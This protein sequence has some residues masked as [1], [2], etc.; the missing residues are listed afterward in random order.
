M[1]VEKIYIRKGNLFAHPGGL[2]PVN[3]SSYEPILPATK[4]A[5][6]AAVLGQLHTGSG[7]ILQ[8]I[9]L[10][11]TEYTPLHE[12]SQTG[13][14]W[15]NYTGNLFPATMDYAPRDISALN[16]TSEDFVTSYHSP[17]Y[18][19]Q[20]FEATGDLNYT[21]RIYGCGRFTFAVRAHEVN[22]SDYLFV[23]TVPLYRAA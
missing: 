16:A 4:Q 10:Q 5:T 14:V 20:A 22:D 1:D 8:M 6:A 21:A 9:S 2:I 15:S 11:Q 12:D 17:Y 7:S 23:C 19:L 13:Y 18:Q 3:F